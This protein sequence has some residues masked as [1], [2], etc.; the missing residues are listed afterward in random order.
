MLGM[1]SYVRPGLVSLARSSRRQLQIRNTARKNV[2]ICSYSLDWTPEGEHRLNQ[3]A[4]IWGR[5]IM[6][7]AAALFGATCAV[8]TV[9]LASAADLSSRVAPLPVMPVAYNWTGFYVGGNGGYGWAN[10]NSTVYALDGA[11]PGVFEASDSSNRNGGF[12]GG[13]IGYNF[14]PFPHFLF[15]VEGD[16]DWASLTGD[17]SGCSLTGCAT[18]SHKTDWFSTLRVRMGYVVDDWLFYGTG[19]IAWTHGS[20]TR[21]ITQV[22]NPALV[23][24]LLG[25]SASSS[26]QNTGWTLGGGV[27]YGFWRN[28]SVNVEYRY[29][30]INPSRDFFFPIPSANRHVSAV[31]DINTV[32]AALNYHFN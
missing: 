23:S 32:R 13:Q 15:G 4:K 8:A 1:P 22:N 27:E 6:R 26:G 25:A 29:M 16:F 30:Q 12:G 11:N 9:Q 7:L 2:Q 24:S 31:E 3:S 28:W 19:G 14:L 17:T 21:T 5:A 10:V 18:S 20:T